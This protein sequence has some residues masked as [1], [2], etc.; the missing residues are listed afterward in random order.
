MYITRD[1]RS[2]PHLDVKH[3]YFKNSLFPSTVIELDN[4]D[5]IM[6][7]LVLFRKRLLAFIRTSGNSTF[8]CHN[9]EAR[10][11]SPLIS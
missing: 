8:H 7:S 4:V 10:I 5:S 3:D 6:R 9:P 11:K 2:I 1:I